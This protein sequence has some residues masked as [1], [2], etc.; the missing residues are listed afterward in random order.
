MRDEGLTSVPLRG[1][2]RAVTVPGCVDGW[3]A[4]H[5]SY[6]RLSLAEVLAPAIDCAAGGF[7][8]PAL[9]AAV[10]PAVADVPGASELVGSL[11]ASAGQLR[12]RPG[13]ARALSEIAADGR[14]A[15]YGG[16]FGAGLIRLGKGLFTPEDL[17]VDAAEWVTPLSLEVPGGVLHLP[18]APSQAYLIGASLG[19][20]S[21]LGAL[22]DDPDDP[23]W[24]HLV[25]EASR[26][27]GF[28]RGIMLH[29]GA[30]LAS[31]LADDSLDRRAELVSA[32]RAGVLDVPTRDGG[33]IYLCAT[34]SRGMSVSLSQSNAS[35]FGAH[36]VVPE[37][38]VF[39]HDR[40][41]GFSLERGHPAELVPGRRP[42]H[43]LSPV[44]MCDLA[45][46]PLVVTGTMG[47]DAQPQVV[48]QIL[49]RLAA[50]ATPGAAIG[51][52]RLALA[53]PL[54]TGFDTWLPGPSGVPV[55]PT[56]LVEAGAPSSWVAG[57]RA[58]GHRVAERPY[59]SGFG[60][61]HAAV[62]VGDGVVAAAS[63]PRAGS[64][65]AVVL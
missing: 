51:A 11:P 65:A 48:L 46:A 42:P 34:D 64:G 47:G 12:R 43:T 24:A 40:G 50:G 54:G 59:G 26:A 61:A 33:T 32:G 4:L 31:V 35:G 7:P 13:I 58:R 16:E 3:L 20:L 30:S 29:D 41:L 15:W 36:I 14:E 52:S 45:G 8:L 27:A 9:L 53:G 44:V 28:D 37:V 5:T 17:A 55:A 19:I 62:F 39:L 6:G 23:V 60:H 49:L 56:V 57:L 38:G 25:V 18:P 22:P 2:I 21:R 10:L 1:D 63:D